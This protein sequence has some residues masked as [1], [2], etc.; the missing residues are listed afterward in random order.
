MQ[1]LRV[2]FI[3]APLS[4]SAS[5]LLADSPAATSTAD[6]I[7]NKAAIGETSHVSGDASGQVRN[8]TGTAASLVEP[9]KLLPRA[10][11]H[12]QPGQAAE[13]SAALA[14]DDGTYT[15]LSAEEISWASNNQAVQV[16]LNGMLQIGQVSDRVRVRLTATAEGFSAEVLVRVNPLPEDETAHEPVPGTGPWPDAA[17][18]GAGWFESQWF[19]SFNVTKHHW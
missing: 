10:P 3:W 1:T 8:A 6:G 11:A 12:V 19:G 17:S 18:L 5:F 2:L 9:V 14:F 16:D 13:A 4:L 15:P 7:V